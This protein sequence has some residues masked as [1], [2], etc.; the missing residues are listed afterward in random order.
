[1]TKRTIIANWKMN[2]VSLKEARAIFNAIKKAAVGM[3]KIETVVCPPFVYL[4]ELKQKGKGVKTGAQDIF[5]D[6]KKTSYTGEVSAGMLKDAGVKYV[7]IGHSERR[8]YLKETNETIN[9]KIKTALKNGFKVVFCVGERSR[10]GG[11]DYLSFIR[12]E[13]EE[14]LRGVP[15]KF[16]KN[17]L[18]AYEPVWAIGKKASEADTPEDVLQMSIYMRRIILPFAGRDLARHFPVLYGGSVNQ[19]N[20]EGFLRDAGIQ[21]LL[22]GRESLIPGNFGEILKIAEQIK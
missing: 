15:R 9:K 7:I 10:A 3:K 4:N 20:A 17:L 22:I 2:P 11:E 5:W 19:R 1:M 8:E 13:I 21:G 16:F 12:K 14:G 18:I 6:D